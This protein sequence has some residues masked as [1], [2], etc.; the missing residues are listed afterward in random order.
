MIATVLLLTAAGL[1]LVT[2]GLMFVRR[3][4]VLGFVAFAAGI[5]GGVIE[6]AAFH[7]PGWGFVWLLSG[8]SALLNTLSLR[9][10]DRWRT[11]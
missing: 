7:Q 3:L 1:Y 11:R 10:V 9:N 6:I 8:F 5:A 4:R 2:L